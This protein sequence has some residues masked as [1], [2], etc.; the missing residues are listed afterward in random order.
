MFCRL[1]LEFGFAGYRAREKKSLVYV[2]RGSDGLEVVLEIHAKL[3]RHRHA[4]NNREYRLM[5][6]QKII[7]LDS[8]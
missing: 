7:F 6:H 4:T 8:F 5:W 2:T 3:L 1:C